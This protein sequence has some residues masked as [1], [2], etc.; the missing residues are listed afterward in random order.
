MPEKVQAQNTESW[1]AT[2][3]SV[4][5]VSLVP[6]VALSLLPL[7]FLILFFLFFPRAQGR[8][9][10][11]PHFEERVQGFLS[12]TWEDENLSRNLSCRAFAMWHCVG[13]CD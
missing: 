1:P 10:Y 3:P 12:G 9:S 11:Y 13:L 6:A 5:I 2:S 7:P 4:A 8:F